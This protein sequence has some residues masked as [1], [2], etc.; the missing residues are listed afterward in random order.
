MT[1]KNETTAASKPEPSPLP[2]RRLSNTE[3]REALFA[4]AAEVQV[5]L[6]RE[7]AERR[8]RRDQSS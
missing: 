3:R 1:A 8:A 6:K 4:Q 2:K 7:A 5:K